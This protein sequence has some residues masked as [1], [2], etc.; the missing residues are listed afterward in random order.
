MQPCTFYE[1][2][3]CSDIELIVNESFKNEMIEPSVGFALDLFQNFDVTSP[4]DRVVNIKI[5][6]IRY[7]K[8]NVD[9]TP[10]EFEYEYFESTSISI[11]Y[12][13]VGVK[14]SMKSNRSYEV[15][16]Y[17]EDAE[18][19]KTT[20]LT[21]SRNTTY[22]P[23]SCSDTK[24]TIEVVIPGT[25]KPPSWATRYGF[26]IKQNRRDYE[27]LYVSQ[28]FQED[29]FCWIKLDGQS[30]DKVSVGDEL[31][32]KRDKRGAVDELVKS[33]IL[34]I[35][36][37]VED[38]I[39]GNQDSSNNLI[40][41]PSGLYAKLDAT[42]LSSQ[43]SENEFITYNKSS[44]TSVGRPELV[45][46]G[47]NKGTEP[48]KIP[49]GSVIEFDCTNRFRGGPPHVEFKKTYIMSTG[50]NNF[51]DAFDNEI[52]PLGFASTNYPDKD[53]LFEVAFS[54]TPGI[55]NLHIVGT[56]TGIDSF[57]TEHKAYMD[58]TVNLRI[59]TDIF[60][61]ETLPK[62]VDTD[63]YFE[64][65]ES[66]QI[67]N[68]E[69]QQTSHLL[70]RTF[71][72]FTFGN[73]AESHQIKDSFNKR[74][75]FIDFCPTSN[76]SDEYK[77]VNRY[78]D[79]TYSDVYQSS[80]SVNRLNEF[81]LSVANYKDDI[82]KR[83]GKVVR[84][85]PTET[86]I[87]VIQEDK[88]SKVLYGKDLLY[89]S[90]ATTNLS[91]IQNVLGQQVPYGGEYGISTHAESF[92]EYGRNMFCTDVK[93]G[94]V[95]RFNDSNGLTEISNNGM[96]DYFKRLFRDNKIDNIIG[97]YD[98]FYD[99]YICNIKY[100]TKTN[101]SKYVTWVYSTDADGFA[102]KQTF[103]PEEMLRVNNHLLSF[104]NGE[105][106]KHN[107]NATNNYNTFYGVQSDSTFSFNFSQEPS[108][109]K[110]FKTIEIE[111]TN[112]WD[113]TL[114]TDLQNGHLNKADLSKKEGVWYG[115][116]RGE[117][118]NA[119]D[120]ATLSVQGL[121]SVSSIV[122]NVVTVDGFSS[123]LV[124][125]GDRVLD[126]NLVFIG[127]ITSISGENITLSS[128]VGASVGTFLVSSKSQSSETSGLLGY[129][130]KVDAKLS[131]N[132]YS[133]VYSVNS[134]AIKSFS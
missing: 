54:G 55:Y 6:A 29:N 112:S 128:V 46:S 4:S 28:L 13:Q 2:D 40:V 8:D 18:G 70:S 117:G 44:S 133:E 115:Y 65:P 33:R 100:T 32:I 98:S 124:S 67:V 49:Q 80:T 57:W 104:K 106:Y 48:L 5:P 9:P 91:R 21:S 15:A 83:F 19:R 77:Q 66:Y 43:Y 62:E 53:Y 22:I 105:V 95:L 94:V 118:E 25:Q 114:K 59:I 42:N 130:M 85:H 72:C 109:R 120:T 1:S 92:D 17:Y 63:I 110:N 75:L 71:N 14:S 129:Y 86:D 132:T 113:I 41:E 34:A 101:E 126:S 119:V 10:D 69:H 127:N 78:A 116:V 35:E 7:I 96:K 38:F 87:L 58:C 111:G 20:A 11:Q 12:N 123:G 31:I 73:G 84:M 76:T 134:E 122:G 68:G 16:M 93:R 88:W 99:I 131:S 27:S 82:D 26:A 64:T 107:Y 3:F 23:A 37:K 81:N 36:S 60:I 90:D 74:K 50:Y 52:A 30:K 121:G 61:F 102:T 97:Q 56:E 24:N 103:N 125:V 108:T 51:K 89:N 47:F 39:V 79:I 45:I